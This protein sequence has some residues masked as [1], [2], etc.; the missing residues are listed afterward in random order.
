MSK[1]NQ[2]E[3]EQPRG[4]KAF[5]TGATGFLGIN[6]VKQLLEQNWEVTVLHRETSNTT[7]LNRFNV[8]SVIGSITKKDSVLKAMPQDVDAVL[9]V[10][11]DTNTWKLK[12]DEQ[13]KNNVDGTKNMVEVAIAKGAKKFIH[14][15]TTSAWGRITGEV[16][17]N[18]PQ[19]GLDSWINY[20]YSECAGEI[21][22][23][24]GLE[25][26]L[27]VVVMNPGGIIGPYDTSTWGRLFFMLR[28]NKLLSIPTGE[29]NFAHAHEVARAHIIAIDKGRRGERYIL[30][31]VHS[32]FE[33]LIK[34]IGIL[35][36]KKIMPLRSIKSISYL[37]AYILQGISYVTK[38]E[39]IYSPEGIAITHYSTINFKSDKA[40]NE[41][42]F[43]MIP[44]KE[45][46]KDCYNW[47]LKEGY[48]KE[49]K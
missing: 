8:K 23:L 3:N 29:M 38:K 47:L 43:K 46:V 2:A 4:K 40:I 39:P 44:V 41:L 37:V 32:S 10:A 33:E 13:T 6:I 11:G 28:D 24:K 25:S 21:E 19:H 1:A 20:E 5:V 31:G 7:F 16:D 17:E 49:R 36:K 15:S 14:T 42:G 45:S 30:G 27:D 9:H 22:A 26:G 12:N 18:T 48:L 34:E 35:L